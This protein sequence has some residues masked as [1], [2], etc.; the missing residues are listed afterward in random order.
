MPSKIID[1]EEIKLNESQLRMVKSGWGEDVINNSVVE[2]I[3]Y[4]SDDLKVKGFF[5]YPKN[6]NG[7][8]FPCI[9]WNR[10]G[11]EN[12]G[13]I[14][15]FN[16]RGIYGQIA[17]WGYIVFA[18]QYRGNDG[19]EGKEQL[20]GNDVNDILNLI[21][22]ADEISFAEK[23]NWG[24]EG[25]SR[26]GMMALLALKKNHSFKCAVLSG[27]I[28]SLKQNTIDNSNLR[29]LY[30]E[31][32]GGNNFDDEIEKRTVINFVNKLP[33]IPYLIMH[34]ENDKTISPLQS[35]EF[36]KKLSKFG[37]NYRLIIFEG[38]DHFLKN[39]R[40]EVDRQRRN[41]FDKYLK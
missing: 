26:G 3:T 24:I 15:L 21:P 34:G 1:R 4:L 38:G 20:G 18:S 41:W 12:K 23:N 9:I 32:I 30:K 28:S 27:A 40:K 16:G 29:K 13:A 22:L 17:S 10:G 31:I 36:A 39:H 35:I 2:K 11:Y 14:D 7:K 33:K 37:Y 6:S 19:G 8:K 25:W 5:A